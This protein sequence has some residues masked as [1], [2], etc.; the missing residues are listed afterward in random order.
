MNWFTFWSLQDALKASV[1]EVKAL[2]AQL[3]DLSGT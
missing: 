3:A 1:A 2:K